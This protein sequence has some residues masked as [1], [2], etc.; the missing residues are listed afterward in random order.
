MSLIQIMGTDEG[1]GDAWPV[2][3]VPTT[4]KAAPP[5]SGGFLSNILGA[6]GKAGTWFEKNSSGVTQV[7]DAAGRLRAKSKQQAADVE[8]AWARNI[9][10]MPPMEPPSWIPGVPN[11]LLIAG[12]AIGLGLLWF[13]VKKKETA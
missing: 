5:S 9:Q 4:Q 7:L 1:L 2:P 6:I 10:Q 8:N 11:G 12:G 3:L 13:L